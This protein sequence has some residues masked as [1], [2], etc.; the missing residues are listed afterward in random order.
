[1]ML[2]YYYDAHI[3]HHPPLPS[4]NKFYN[5]YIG[6]ARL[7]NY[8]IISG[9]CND[10]IDEKL[11]INHYDKCLRIVMKRRINLDDGVVIDIAT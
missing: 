10:A 2:F 6:N 5:L 1:M 7:S 8:A 3:N 9:A 4:R 11:R